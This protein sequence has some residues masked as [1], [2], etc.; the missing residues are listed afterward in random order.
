MAVNHLFLTLILL[1]GWSPAMTHQEARAFIGNVL[2][3]FETMER[4]AELRN[5]RVIVQHYRD[6]WLVVCEAY[7]GA[8]EGPAR[9]KLHTSAAAAAHVCPVRPR[10]FIQK[11]SRPMRKVVA[12]TS[13]TVAG[14]RRGDE[15]TE[16]F[17]VLSCGHLIADHSA[18]HETAPAK[19]R[20]C[21]QCQS[22]ASAGST[23]APTLGRRVYAT[24]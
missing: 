4:A 16:H 8:D 1:W 12:R 5:K 10:W 18:D 7:Y 15:Y 6:C 14:R 20:R 3:Y 2:N 24:A 11:Y 23:A 19:H 22:T 13:K 9:A 21:E 17:D